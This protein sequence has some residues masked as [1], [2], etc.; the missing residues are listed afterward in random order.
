MMIRFHL[1]KVWLIEPKDKLYQWM[2]MSSQLLAHSETLFITDDIVADEN[3]DK[4]RQSLLEL[5]ISG[6]HR[7]HCLWSLHNLT[8]RYLTISEGRPRLYLLGIQKKGQILKWCMMK[9]MC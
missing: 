7:N 3:L 1:Y 6:R 9:T 8:L 5:A 2:E 4:R